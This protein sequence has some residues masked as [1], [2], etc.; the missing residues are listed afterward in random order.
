MENQD[1]LYIPQPDAPN[2][3]PVEPLLQR[4]IDEQGEP[5]KPFTEW[6]KT[7]KVELEKNHEAEWKELHLVWEMIDKFIE[8]KQLLRRK[9]RAFGWDVIPMPDSTASRI[10]EQNKLGFYSHVL[11]S[12]WVA[13]RTTISAI[14]GDD[15]DEAVGA[16]RAAQLLWD[17]IEPRIF[18]EWFRQ[19]EALSGQVHGTYARYFGFDSEGEPDEYGE[20]PVTS[21][22]P[23]KAGADM[24]EC[25]DCG[26]VG[27]ASQ[28][29]VG[30]IPQENAPIP[31]SA[32]LSNPDPAMAEGGGEMDSQA[33]N[34]GRLL[35]SFEQPI[36]PTCGSPNVNVSQAPESQIEVVTGKEQ[37]KLGCLRGIPVPYSQL[38]HEISLS[39]EKSP[40]ARWSR[41]VRVEEV[42]A[43]FPGL[44]IPPPNSRGKDTGLE[45]EERMR[46]STAA[47]TGM[48]T[49]LANSKHYVDFSQWWFTPIMYADYTFPADMATVQ[50]E[51]IPAGTKA[52]EMFPDGMY[53]AWCEGIDTPLMLS[54]E[55][56][57]DHFVT[58]PYHIR[59]FTGLGYG[60][61]DAVE[62]QR[63]WNIT[64]SL[65]FEQ[66]RSASLPG[67]LY[68]KD[69]IGSDDVKLLGQPQNNVPVSLRNRAEGTRIQEL[70]HQMP[71]GQIPA[72]IP[73]Y[74]E[75]LDS[76]MQTSMGALVNE[77]VPGMDSKTATGAQLM[78]S[79]SAQHNAP[80]FA[81]KGDADVKSAYLLFALAQKYFVDKRY[82]PLTGK[83]GKQDGIW[84]SASD[85]SAGKVRFEAVKDSWLPS[86]KLEKQEATQK[87][88]L[89][90]GGVQ[91]LLMAQQS[92]PDFVADVAAAFN[93]DI[94]GDIFE[95]TSILCRQRVDQIKMMAPQFAQLAAQMQIMSQIVPQVDPMTGMPVD[96]MEMIGQQMVAA[97]KPEVIIE[98]PGHMLS[99]KW[100]RDLILDDEMKE[101]DPLTR[102]GVRALIHTHLQMAA[103]EQM[104]MNQFALATQPQPEM[105]ADGEPG[106][107]QKAV[108]PQQNAQASK[109]PSDSN[110]DSARANMKMQGEGS[111]G[112]LAKRP[113]PG[114]NAS[115]IPAGNA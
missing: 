53:V 50:G 79:A 82:F 65:V 9:H 13:S 59:L 95:P 56:H 4:Y 26:N 92:M 68:D 84:L 28:Y 90:F 33:G 41:R 16:A 91:G 83:R 67:W 55:K 107:G 27:E 71:P 60:I 104:I 66:I 115:H 114:K 89:M 86:S 100:L 93:V 37:V 52:I 51:T 110:R 39:L 74:I 47:N 19:T 81:L 36:C 40:W 1:G 8:G 30:G 111:G 11:M 20:R 96:P 94:E 5:Q 43:K 10:R 99:V 49:D 76:N 35:P 101:A 63:Q 88:L 77:G 6:F 109:T 87:L 97:L 113:Y 3:A 14:P 17:A 42:K 32:S 61:N 78:A 18:T 80:E 45:Y 73:W 44:K 102:A 48:S 103:Q 106:A 15:S 12:K 98:E 58:A 23:F 64:L 21:S 112:A 57:T 75:K 29:G 108:G 72:H 31:V 38:R 7:K 24:A 54:N 22:I 62:M 34:P 25:L 85:L 69:A 46:R 105:Q 2:F 70:V